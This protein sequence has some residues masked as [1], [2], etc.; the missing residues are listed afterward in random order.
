M[1]YNISDFFCRDKNKKSID[2]LINFIYSCKGQETVDKTN[3]IDDL[4][5]ISSLACKSH[6]K[7]L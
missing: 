1:G 2:N 5:N 6:I 4:I 7:N 3:L